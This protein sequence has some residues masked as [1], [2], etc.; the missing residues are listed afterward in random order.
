MDSMQ[1]RAGLATT[2]C[3]S[4]RQPWPCGSRMAEHRS[5]QYAGGL[6]GAILTAVKRLIFPGDAGAVS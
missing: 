3:P 6:M 1:G 2:S 4:S 5:S